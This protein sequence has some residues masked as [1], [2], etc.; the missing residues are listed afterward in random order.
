MNN[1]QRL[2][3]VNAAATLDLPVEEV[4]KSVFKLVSEGKLKAAHTEK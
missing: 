4:E 3:V 2:N 1:N